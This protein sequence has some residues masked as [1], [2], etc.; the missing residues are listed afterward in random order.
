MKMS[1]V[2][3]LFVAGLSA[4][5]SAGAPV[6]GN[7]S[8]RDVKGVGELAAVRTGAPPAVVN[9]VQFFKKDVHE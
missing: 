8:F 6:G 7:T 5:V 1:A 4:S 2:L 3:F 9:G